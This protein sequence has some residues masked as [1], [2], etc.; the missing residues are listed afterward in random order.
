MK[1]RKHFLDKYNAAK[2]K[3]KD[4]GVFWEP[5]SVI[6]GSASPDIL[7]GTLYSVSELNN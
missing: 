2:K 6:F 5:M 1:Y 4:F 7:G 3:T